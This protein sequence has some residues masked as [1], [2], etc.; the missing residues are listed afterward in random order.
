MTTQRKLLS[1]CV[2][3]FNEQDNIVPLYERVCSVMGE[4]AD[5]YDFELVFTDNH[6]IDRTFEELA[7]LARKDP[8]VRV[9]R[10]SRNFGFQKS[11]LT[12]YL[13]ARGDAAIQLDCDLQDPPEMILEFIRLWEQGYKVVYGVRKKRPGDSRVLQQSRKI[14][15]RLIDMLSEEHLPHDAGDFRLIDRVILDYLG[16]IQDQ[17]PYI[18]GIIATL[19]YRQIGV[20][21]DRFARERG[22]SK[23][24]L[25]RLISL[26]MDGILNHSVLPLRIATFAGL[27]M[28]A[29]AILGMVY[30]AFARWMFRGD[31]PEGLASTSILLLFSI[32]MNSLLLGI[33]GEYLG[34]IYKNVKRAPLTII[35]SRI[36]SAD[37]P[38]P[39]SGQRQYASISADEEP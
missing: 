5:R 34:R 12:N 39:S 2:P 13:N 17:Q 36:E 6:S 22:E 16:T 19:G 33:I 18:R 15:Y 24:N 26:G 37:R 25:W 11:I 38:M 9:I 8:R 35:E 28:F 30:Y 3:V 31:W 27:I 7:A 32:G 21:Y 4:I 29:L 1:I 14:F 23:F 10:F 20:P